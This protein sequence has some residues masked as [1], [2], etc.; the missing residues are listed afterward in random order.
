MGTR[1]DFNRL[2]SL[3]G[4]AKA[5]SSK[6]AVADVDTFLSAE[7]GQARLRCAVPTGLL[8]WWARGACHRAGGRPDPLALPTLRRFPMTGALA[9]RPH[10]IA[11]QFVNGKSARQQPLLDGEV[12]DG[13]KRAAIG[14]D[15]EAQRIEGRP[16]RSRERMP[17]C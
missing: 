8:R 10:G 12:D 11:E 4:W 2:E 16:R 13:L 15:A 3:V 7:V 6:S 1:A 17:R 14:F 5:R 9:K